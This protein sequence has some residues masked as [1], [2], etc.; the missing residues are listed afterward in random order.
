MATATKKP[1]T[2]KSLKQPKVPGSLKPPN[3]IERLLMDRSNPIETRVEVL[4][5]L[6]QSADGA[7]LPILA[8]V[9]EAASTATGE[10]QYGARLA[11]LSE[12]I[13][14]LQEGPLRSALF[15]RMLDDPGLD[16]RAQVIL[17]DGVVASVLLPDQ[18]LAEKLR[19]GDTVW[20]D[21][22]GTAVLF[23][24]PTVAS[25]GAVGEEARLE[26]VLPDG[27]ILVAVG[28]LSR[29]VYRPS[30][31]LS[32]QLASG[33]AEPGSTLIVCQRRNIAFR[34]LPEADGPSHYQF[35]S[36]EPVPDV[37][38][39]RD[40][41]APPA[42]IGRVTNYLRR[43]LDDPSITGRYRLRRSKVHM[44][45]GVPGTGKT[46][47]ILALWNAMYAILSE[48]IGVPVEDLPQ[49]VMRL[50]PSEVLSQWLGKSDKQIARFFAEVDRLASE[51]FEGPDG[52]V[53]ELPVLVI[54]E[55]ID[56]LGRARGEDGV[57]DRIQAT[58]LEG[59]DPDRQVYKEKLVFV[60]ATTNAPHL[61]DNAVIRRVSALV[62]T[63]GHM[64]RFTF[65]AVLDK[66]LRGLPFQESAKE[67]SEAACSR[68]IADVTAWLYGPN[69]TAG[70]QVEVTFVGQANPDKKYHRDFLT[71][72]LIDRAVQD[73]SEISADA[74]YAGAACP[75]LT[76]ELVLSAIDQQV[77]QIVDLL[78]PHNAGQYLTLPD[79]ERVATVRR[80]EQPGVTP[81]ELERAS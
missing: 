13:A 43:E 66:H 32:E 58:L 41:G 31:R 78:T 76:T 28:E 39:D 30:A 77:R 37:V 1:K 33:E 44:L 65:R 42:F 47:G 20:I 63:F 81:F 29:A 6:A 62:E 7:A 46:Y 75:G 12:M 79:G 27:T 17:P 49:R 25:I 61:V 70:G 3:R 35:V 14:A 71:A 24:S 15:E 64:D 74:E 38:V 68:T 67:D 5:Q 4:R 72:G 54:A 60:I 18:A 21:A 40:L 2:G 16:R 10:D 59:L 50:R 69:S 55:E 36:D 34:A 8:Q 73:A 45:A 57:Q 11:E 48:V 52:R 56:A 19:C 80:I 22:K 53:W 26:R 51:T 9:L 23:H